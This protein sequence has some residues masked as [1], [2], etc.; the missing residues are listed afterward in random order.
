MKEN[1]LWT[2]RSQP[3]PAWLWTSHPIYLRF[4]NCQVLEMG[5]AGMGK[6]LEFPTTST[7]KD[8]GAVD[9]Q[10]L[11]HEALPP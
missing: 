4:L 11:S 1:E 7:Q 2:L 6:Y 9:I 10:A 3:R 8:N 5:A